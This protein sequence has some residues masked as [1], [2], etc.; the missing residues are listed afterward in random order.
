MSVFA[1]GDLH[2]SLTTN[3]EMDV[4]GGA[5]TNYVEKIQ[6]GFSV[7]CEDDVCILCGDLSWGMS[8]EEAL[9]DFEFVE[10]LPGRKIM[11]KGNHD[12]WWTTLSKMTDF[13]TKN[14]VTTIDVLHNNH[15]SF[16]ETAICGTRGWMFDGS[17]GMTHNKKILARE[18]ARLKI[19]LQA[20]GDAA[21]KICFFHYPPRF[22]DFVCAEII[23]VM[24]EFGVKKCYYGHIHGTGHNYAVQGIVE[25]I[26]FRM[27][28]ADYINFTP[29]KV[30]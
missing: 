2:L 20:A 18:A 4:F 12:Y 13:F 21:E 6:K 24:N 28:S 27:I 16:G 30:L 17:E 26:D 10:K 25:G 23:D 22:K 1:I 5:W 7:V 14:G 19:S 11:L 9:P 3:K 29:V 15:F 8:L